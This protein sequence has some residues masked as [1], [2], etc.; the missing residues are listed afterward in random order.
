MRGEPDVD[1]QHPELAQH[2]QDALLG[3]DRQRE[4]GEIDARLARVF[5][6]IVDV[7]ELGEAFD[8]QRRAGVAAIV[9]HAEQPDLGGIGLGEIADEVAREFAAADHD[10][11][12]L[13]APGGGEPVDDGRQAEARDR[14]QR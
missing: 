1:R 3:G 6:E 2:L 12:L 11:A 9:E 10:D 13:K 4:D 14:Q 8:R 7:A 5:D